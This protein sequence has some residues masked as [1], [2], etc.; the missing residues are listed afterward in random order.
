M[1][2]LNVDGLGR[3]LLDLG[4]IDNALSDVVYRQSVRNFNARTR[5][6]C[7]YR[8]CHV[9]RLLALPLEHTLEL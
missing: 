1:P 3:A 8:L 9:P 6:K 7:L 4:Q 5:L 2:L